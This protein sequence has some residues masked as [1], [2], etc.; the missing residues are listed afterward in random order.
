MPDAGEDDFPRSMRDL[1]VLRNRL[2][3][4]GTGDSF[5]KAFSSSTNEAVS[6]RPFCN[7][8]FG[9]GRV[10]GK[11]SVL[12]N[13]LHLSRNEL[14]EPSLFSDD[15]SSSRSKR[16]FCNGFFGCGN[17]GKR[18][19]FRS[20]NGEYTSAELVQKRFI[21]NPGTLGCKTPD[22]R[23]PEETLL[24]RIRMR[25]LLENNTL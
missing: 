13:K 6:K 21:C 1:S 4:L 11:R 10:N 25:T 3:G 17:P 22:Q 15:S 2:K 20:P 7:G 14:H 5:P 19:V 16:P 24:E 9:C 8:F 18:I 12:L 23:S